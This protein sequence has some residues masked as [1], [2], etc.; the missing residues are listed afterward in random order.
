MTKIAV[1]F[2]PGYAE[3]GCTTDLVTRA[4]VWWKMD[5]VRGEGGDRR[6]L[7]EASCQHAVASLA[8]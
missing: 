6:S 4:C 2:L 1:F 7:V 3:W 8:V 5:K